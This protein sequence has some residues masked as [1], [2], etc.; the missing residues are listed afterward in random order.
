MCVAFTRTASCKGALTDAGAIESIVAAMTSDVNSSSSQ[1]A[2]AGALRNFAFGSGECE[3]RTYCVG[4]LVCVIARVLSAYEYLC[5]APS[6]LLHSDYS[7]QQR[8][9]S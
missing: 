8:P 1:E 9:D 2:C 6:P 5:N 4:A 3:E 7:G